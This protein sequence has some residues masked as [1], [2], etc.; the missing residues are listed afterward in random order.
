M[1]FVIIVKIRRFVATWAYLASAFR[2]S[3]G[4]EK[5]WVP[6][7]QMGVVQSALPIEHFFVDDVGRHALPIASTRAEA[8]LAAGKRDGLSEGR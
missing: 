5:A 4:T 1:A 6:H 2:P 3:C 7:V 8:S